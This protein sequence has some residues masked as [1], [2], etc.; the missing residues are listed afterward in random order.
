[1][2]NPVEQV[3]LGMIARGTLAF[4][5]DNQVEV[6]GERPKEAGRTTTQG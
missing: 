3:Q 6:E 1:M 2:N 4:K 5:V